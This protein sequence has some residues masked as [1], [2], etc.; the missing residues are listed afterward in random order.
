MFWGPHPKGW[1]RRS[2]LAIKPVMSIDLCA[3]VGKG[4]EI[5]HARELWSKAALRHVSSFARVGLRAVVGIDVQG[6]V[7][8][9]DL[10]EKLIPTR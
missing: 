8:A 4:V 7:Y 9:A 5:G 2:Q 10:D 3:I 6:C 1:E